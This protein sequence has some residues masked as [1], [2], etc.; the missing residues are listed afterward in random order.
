MAKDTIISG[1]VRGVI[2]YAALA[3]VGIVGYSW[4]NKHGY[5]DGVKGA[6]DSAA[7]L[8]S[9]IV[10]TVKEKTALKGFEQIGGGDFIGGAQTIIRRTTPLGLVEH[11][12]TG[13]GDSNFENI[14]NIP[15]MLP[16][17]PPKVVEDT[18]EW[19]EEKTS[20]SESIWTDTP[21]KYV[22]AVAVRNKLVSLFGH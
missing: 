2:P 13:G 5:L 10:N 9:Q 20:N 4:L 18:K 11:V 15:D 21:L 12:L 3:A 8:P 22:P 14:P 7:N 6:L 17:D 16:D 1:I 19:V